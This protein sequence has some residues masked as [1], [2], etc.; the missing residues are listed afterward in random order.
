MKTILIFFLII[1]SQ[2]ISC[3]SN[4]YNHRMG[5]SGELLLN[6]VIRFS[7]PDPSLNALTAAGYQCGFN[8][9]HRLKERLWL[10]TGVGYHYTRHQIEGYYEPWLMT[11]ESEI[12]V[13]SLGLAFEF[14][15]WLNME[16]GMLTHYQKT[17]PTN[18][19]HRQSGLGLFSSLN[20]QIPLTKRIHAV[21]GPSL[22]VLSLLPF[23]SE[24]HQQRFL[25]LGLQCGLFTAL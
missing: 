6:D 11:H 17:T 15:Q 2:A 25:L 21:T 23:R 20:I 4:S 7:T 13:H 14:T 9:Q 10:H 18:Y 24:D 22:S 16:A 3:Q 19:I 8:Y 1:V 12:F 5:I